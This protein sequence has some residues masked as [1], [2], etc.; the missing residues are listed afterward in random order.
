[1]VRTPQAALSKGG[2]INILNKNI[3]FLSS[4]NFK[5]LKFHPLSLSPT[6]LQPGLG[7]GL[8]QQ[9]PPSFPV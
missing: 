5:V 1:M 2:R 6:A 4:T 9:F 7:L 8:L 3:D